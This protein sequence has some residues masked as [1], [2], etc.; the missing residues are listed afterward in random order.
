MSLLACPDCFSPIERSGCPGCGRAFEVTSGL[1]ALRR[2][3]DVP[4]EAERHYRELYR[5]DGDPWRYEGRA[6]EV[7]KAERVMAAFDRFAPGDAVVVEAGCATG[8]ITRRLAR[9]RCRLVVF[10]L[11]PAAVELTRRSIAGDATARIDWCSASATRLPIARGSADLVLLL[12][13]PISWRLGPGVF[14]QV[15]DEA[16]AALKPGG[17]LLVMDYL[18]PRRFEELR[19]PVRTRFE[20]VSD[21]PLPDR[22]WYVLESALRAL[23]GLRP[24]RWLFSQRW[25]ARALGAV[26]ALLGDRGA[27]HLLLVC[28]KRS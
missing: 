25:L 27:K 22:L 9:R 28:R 10:D 20:V 26:S 1:P 17:H 15:L 7:L 13:G 21:E 2:K 6:A 8:H 24:I 18:N 14:E 4:D 12:D 19:G 23:R 3:E 11:I 16:G 5:T